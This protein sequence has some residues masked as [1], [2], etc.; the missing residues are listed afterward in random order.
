MAGV[1]PQLAFHASGAKLFYHS[2]GRVPCLTRRKSGDVHR[3]DDWLKQ[4]VSA[5]W[6]LS[7]LTR[8]F[9]ALTGLLNKFITI[10]SG[11]VNMK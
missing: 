1:L 7:P 4:V 2:S 9:V 3:G 5:R 8:V 10:S 11:N 6:V